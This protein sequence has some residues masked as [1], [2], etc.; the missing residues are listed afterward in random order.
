MNLWL[1]IDCCPEH[2]SQDTARSGTGAEEASVEQAKVQ[3]GGGGRL[4]SRKEGE[5]GPV[6]FGLFGEDCKFVFQFFGLKVFPHFKFFV[7]KASHSIKFNHF[8]L[9][10]V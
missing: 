5:D 3:G 2:V 10:F 7:T 6:L 8:C 9:L 4:R 1:T